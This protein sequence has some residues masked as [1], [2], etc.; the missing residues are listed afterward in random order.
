MVDS[1]IFDL[2]GTLWDASEPIYQYWSRFMPNQTLKSVQKLLG[3]TIKEM[4]NQT[5]ISE[6]HLQTLQQGENEHL[7]ANPGKLYAKV[8]PT[9]EVLYSKGLKLFI[10][11]NCQSGYIET[12]LSTK[13]LSKYFEGHICFGDTKQPKQI[14]VNMLISQYKLH[15]IMVGDTLSD[16]NAAQYNHIPFIWV[17]YGFGQLNWPKR[18]DNLSD[19]ILEVSKYEYTK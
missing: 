19:L 13:G 16:L 18:V 4:A 8:I 1:I 9:L 5:G 6:E 10:A 12:F 14:N 2:D 15:P 17:S 3:L 11:S 7:R